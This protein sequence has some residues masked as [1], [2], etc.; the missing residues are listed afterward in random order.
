MVYTKRTLWLK[1]N[2][3]FFSAMV[4][5]WKQAISVTSSTAFFRFTIDW[6]KSLF[7]SFSRCN[8][9]VLDIFFF[10][11]LIWSALTILQNKS[12]G[13]MNYRITWPFAEIKA[14]K[15]GIDANDAISVTPFSYFFSAK[16]KNSLN[17]T[18]TMIG[19]SLATICQWTQNDLTRMENENTYFGWIKVTFKV[20]Q[21]FFSQAV[22]QRW[23]C[24]RAPAP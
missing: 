3:C 15:F 18:H 24:G 23:N 5:F 16:M 4:R 8:L 22:C 10:L 21:Y 7:V 6:L 1:F 9:H 20:L 11:G 13:V 2:A 19:I 14:T 17:S 12:C